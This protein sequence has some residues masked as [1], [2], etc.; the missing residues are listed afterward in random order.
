[1][2]VRLD[3]SGTPA[4]I[5]IAN[6]GNGNRF[7]AAMM[8][9]FAEALRAVESAGSPVLVLDSEGGDFTFG[10]DQ[11]ERVPGLSKRDNLTKILTVNDLLSSASAVTVA[12]IR[13]HAFG[14]GTGLSLHAD[15]TVA[16][17]DAVFAFDEIAHGLAPLVVVAY[18]AKYVPEKIARELVLT[19]REVSA[20]EA[21]RLAVVNRVVP[22]ER[23]D[24]EVAELVAGLGKRDPGALR[25]I[26]QYHRDLRDD[27]ETELG[28]RAVARLADWLDAR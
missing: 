18:L 27:R 28:Q 16:A 13:G 1:M 15:L 23:V 5:T 10:R 17:D 22:P 21:G 26:K 6:P 2:T 7:T 11:R 12:A 8:D 25:L 19:G 3:L 4:R 24:D 9:E 20:E 14:F